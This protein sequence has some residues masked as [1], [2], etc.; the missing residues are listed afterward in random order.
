MNANTSKV[1]LFQK[2]HRNNFSDYVGPDSWTFFNLLQIETSLLDLP[3]V[4]WPSSKLILHG[5]E[6]F[7]QITMVNDAA[8]QTLGLATVFN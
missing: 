6:L 5:K 3:V 2:H 7:S 8:E 4:K 1:Q